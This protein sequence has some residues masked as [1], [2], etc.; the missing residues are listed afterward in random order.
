MAVICIPYS[1]DEQVLVDIRSKFTVYLPTMDQLYDKT[2][3]CS[4][5]ESHS[6]SKDIALLEVGGYFAQCANELNKTSHKKI[7]GIIEDTEAG[8]RKYASACELPFPVISV[9]R[10]QLKTAEDAVIGPSAVFSIEK[11]LR[12][13]DKPIEGLPAT[14]LGYGKIGRGAALALRA[15]NCVV[16]V[17]D[18]NPVA[19]IQ[20]LAEGHKIPSKSNALR[21]ADLI[22]GTSGC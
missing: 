9:A 19:R 17:F 20:A 5:V 12:A 6:N 7:I 13:I 1:I 4:I 22:I 3:L 16:Y 8:H 21:S 14:V 15:K 2:Y 10:S 18:T 11:A